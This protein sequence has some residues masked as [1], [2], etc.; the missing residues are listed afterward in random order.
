MASIS[1]AAGETQAFVASQKTR[2]RESG[3]M[4]HPFLL[5]F[6]STRLDRDQLRRFAIQWYKTAR[7]HKLAFPALVLNTRDDDIR[8]D[9]IEILNEEYGSGD[10]EKIHARL[11]MHFLRALGAEEEDVEASPT[12]G[13]V[14]SFSKRV[15]AI[16]RDADPIRAFGLHFALEYLASALHAHFARG[17]RKYEF[18]SQQ[19]RRYFDYHEEAEPHHADFSELGM[20]TYADTPSNR[21]LLELGVE[22]GIQLLG[23]LWDEFDAHVFA[24]A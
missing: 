21:C 12:L 15:L 22:E 3:V 18:L 6:A 24:P 2:M 9:L 14:D 7:A 13:A 19:D 1:T 20:H 17:L 4:D 11:L 10:R 23:Q 5:R 8:F 16:W